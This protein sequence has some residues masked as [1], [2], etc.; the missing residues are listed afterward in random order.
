M[1]TRDL[2]PLFQPEG[3]STASVLHEEPWQGRE[4]L[5]S[6]AVLVLASIL[7]VGLGFLFVTSF[8]I[9]A[10]PLPF[11][12]A[13]II[14]VLLVAGI[15]ITTITSKPVGRVRAI[16][17]GASVAAA[18][19][20][21]FLAREMGVPVIVAAACVAIVLGVMSLPG[22]W[23]DAGAAGAGYTGAFVGMLTPGVTLG[24]WWVLGAAVIAGV[25]WSL[26]G[27]SVWDGV[28][29]RMGA[30]A[31]IAASGVYLV[32]N[33]VDAERD[34]PL[35]PGMDGMAHA[36]VVPIG[37]AAALVTWVLIQRADM[38]FVLASGLTSLAVCGVI[39]LA[40]PSG[41]PLAA[42]WFG[43]TFVGAAGVNRLPNAFWVG[44]AGLVFGALT[45]HFSG[46]L[47]GHVGVL[48][49]TAVIASLAIGAIE[50]VVLAPAVQQRGHALRLRVRPGR[51]VP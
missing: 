33:L 30:V 34:I 16:D 29:G 38:G 49:A 42:A 39:A 15:A 5:P 23:L 37:C 50:W 40:L 2:S 8:L 12:V 22:Q 6:P 18:A 28:G 46:P 14:G 21:L 41:S 51:S 47:S 1:S 26:V 31:Y 32:A 35:L 4:G 44:L 9:G 25:L 20:T 7:A 24:T 11:A 43:G 3:R 27:P 45:L 10:T 19:M 48:G 17:V 13:I 36:A